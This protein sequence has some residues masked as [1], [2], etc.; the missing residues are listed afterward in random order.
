MQRRTAAELLQATWRA[1]TA[2]NELA[3]TP[4]LTS[5]TGKWPNDPE[6]GRQAALQ[7]LDTVPAKT[8]WSIPNF[9]EAVHDAHPDFMRPPGG[10]DSWYLQ[11]SED[12]NLHGFESWHAIEGQ[13]IEYL[14]T[15]PMLWLGLTEVS[16]NRSAFRLSFAIRFGLA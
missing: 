1:S 2:W 10:F 11:S 4:G 15:G 5:P 14:I 6:V 3:H 9:V 13:F 12:R 16:H 8:W 7:L